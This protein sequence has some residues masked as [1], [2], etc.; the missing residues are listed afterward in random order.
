[1]NRTIKAATVTLSILFANAAMAHHTSAETAADIKAHLVVDGQSGEIFSSY[2]PNERRYPASITKMMTLALL[3][4]HMRENN[5]AEDT[6]IKTSRHAARVEPSQIGLLEGESISYEKA[7]NAI[8]HKSA[9]DVASAIAEHIAG[10]EEA[11]AV[12]MNKRAKEWGMDNTNFANPHGLPNKN[13]YTTACDM[14]KM[15]LNLVREYPEFQEYPTK[16]YIEHN[17]KTFGSPYAMNPSHRPITFYKGGF[18]R[19]SQ[20]TAIASSVYGEHRLVGATFGHV[21]RSGYGVLLNDFYRHHR[22]QM[23]FEGKNY[24]DKDVIFPAQLLDCSGL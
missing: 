15:T 20:R 7:I 3:F 24:A 9:N 5:H 23:D 11:F 1:M 8:L 6:P 21:K 14:T 4:D 17:G 22:T 2:K 16:R 13:H 10:S 12:L 19:A 18:T